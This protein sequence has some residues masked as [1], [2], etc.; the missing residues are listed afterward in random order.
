V[1]LA[2]RELNQL[3]YAIFL[4]RHLHCWASTAVIALALHGA[5][6][7]AG[8]TTAGQLLYEQKCAGCHAVDGNRVGPA[9][10][11][12]FGRKAGRVPDFE[13]SS[14]LKNSEVIWNE[15]TLQAWLADP[16]KLIAGQSMYFRVTS[17]QSQQDIIAY[18][19]TLTP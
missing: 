1:V 19:A 15:Q 18:L 11:G 13:Y 5:S 8:D 3:N 9:H 6:W 12:V 4:K 7:A 17:A 16:E 14:A 2:T 10:R